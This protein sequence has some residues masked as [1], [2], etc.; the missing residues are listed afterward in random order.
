MVDGNGALALAAMVGIVSPLLSGPE[1]GVLT[2]LL[3][4]QAKFSFPA[5]HTISVL[6]WKLACR[7]SNVDIKSHSCDLTFGS[8]DVALTGRKAH[9]L[10][11]TLAE[12]GAPPDGAA[13][14]IFEAVSNLKCTINPNEVIQ[15]S[16]GGAHCDYAPPN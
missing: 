13:G 16:G 9:E 5:G 3:D 2:T 11:S 6:A 10:F 15:N 12:I 7:A 4:G 8:H 1:Q 14:S